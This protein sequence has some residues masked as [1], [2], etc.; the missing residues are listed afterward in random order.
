MHG[1]GVHK[2]TDSNEIY[3]GQFKNGITH[4]FGILKSG[5]NKCEGQWKKGALDGFGLK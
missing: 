1:K 3:I 5:S 2:Q 4:G